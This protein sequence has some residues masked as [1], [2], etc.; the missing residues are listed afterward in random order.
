LLEP[1]PVYPA[2]DPVCSVT[3][4]LTISPECIP[5]SFRADGA[6]TWGANVIDAWTRSVSGTGVVVA[7]LDGGSLPHPDI[8]ANLLPGYDFVT[9]ADTA[10]DGNGRDSDPTDAGLPLSSSPEVP[11]VW[12]GLHV[13]GTIGAVDNTI[14]V[15]GVSP[16]AKILPVRVLGNAGGSSCDVIAG[17]RWA[18]GVGPDV[19]GDQMIQCVPGAGP[20]DPDGNTGWFGTAPSPAVNPYPAKVLNLSLG[21][22]AVNNA[23]D[24][25]TQRAVNDAIAAGVVVVAAAGNNNNN[26]S[27]FSPANCTG[28]ITV[29]ATNGSGT[30]ASFSNWGPLV[31]LSAPG[32]GILSLYNTGTKAT[33]SSMMLNRVRSR[34]S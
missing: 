4:A 33:G 20:G 2:V 19:T 27:S 6:S 10:N 8:T 22:P 5:R 26:A 13:M 16:A 30:K 14:G 29:G 21:G 18:A 1:Y 11:A 24:T 17:I 34:S 7:V 28:V 9:D 32:V 31:N 23:C 15:K 25:P 12:H 3:S